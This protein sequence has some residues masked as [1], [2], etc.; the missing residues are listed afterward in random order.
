MAAPDFGIGTTV[1]FGTSGFSADILSIDG[2]NQSRAFADTTHMGTT[3]QRTKI[4]FDLV[5]TGNMSMEVQF[6]GGLVLPIAE[7][8]ETITID[9]G[10][11]GVGFKY[12]FTGFCTEASITTSVEDIMTATLSIEI[13]GAITQS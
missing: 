7:V 2:P 5:D 6:D 13:T 3:G 8:A 4:P 12:S 11:T 9:Y 10:G 1:T